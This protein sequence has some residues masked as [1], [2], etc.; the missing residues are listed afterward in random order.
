MGR[1]HGRPEI[2]ESSAAHVH[3]RIA[4]DYPARKGVVGYARSKAADWWL[5]HSG[6][7][8]VPTTVDEARSRSRELTMPDE[9]LV[10]P[11]GKYFTITN[12]RVREKEAA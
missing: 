1:H 3:P 4:A 12:A 6:A 11:D 8:P 9:I 5:K 2:V 10:K 7:L